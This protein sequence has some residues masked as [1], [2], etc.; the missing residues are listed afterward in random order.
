MPQ[1][2]AMQQPLKQQPL[3]PQQPMQPAQEQLPQTDEQQNKLQLMQEADRRGLLQGEM[4][5]IFDEAVRRG[6]IQAPHQ[7]Q[8]KGFRDTIRE[9]FSGAD[10]STPELEA[11]PNI[12]DAPE[13]NSLSMPAFKSSLGFLLTG[14]AE[15]QK[16][17][18]ESNFPE[19][20]FR[21][22]EKGNT[23]VALG[24][25]EYALQK[26]GLELQDIARLFT[27]YAAF[28][29]A[30]KVV[31]TTGKA[32]HGLARAFQVAKKTAATATG[33]E[34]A[35]A[36]TG[37]G[38][39]PVNIA[40]DTA[41]SGALEAVPVGVRALRG[42]A[43]K[44]A[45][46]A[47]SRAAR[48]E[49]ERVGSPVSPE[50][51]AARQTEIAEDIA[52]AARRPQQ[53][54]GLPADVQAE[55]KV[56]EAAEALDVGDVPLSVVTGD[57]Q[58]REIYE[59]L[60]SRVGSVLNKKKIESVA[61]VQDAAE[62]TI[63]QLGG[64]T[65]KAELTGAIKNRVTSEIKKLDVE[66][67]NAYN[68]V[69]NLL[70]DNTQV[71]MSGIKQA[72]QEKASKLSNVSLKDG[73]SK[74]DTLSR[75]FLDMSDSETFAFIDQERRRIGRAINKGQGIYKDEDTGA[76]KQLYGMLTDAQEQAAVRTSPE[77]AGIW[78][79]AK[80]LV[81]TRKTLEDNSVALLGKKLSD[82]VMSKMGRATRGLSK[83]DMKE[84]NEIMNA[85]PA[86]MRQEVALSSLADAFNQSGGALNFNNFNKWFEGMNRN[87]TAKDAFMKHLPD[88][89]QQRLDHLYTLSKKFE[90]AGKERITTGRLNELFSIDNTSD[91]L[92]GVAEGAVAGAA[93]AATGSPIAGGII[94][95][96]SRGKKETRVQAADRLLSSPE[97]E[98]LVRSYADVS[99]RGKA[100]QEVAAN[101]LERSTKYQRWVDILP[102]DEALNLLRSGTIA[103]FRD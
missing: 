16:G 5:D 84:F 89:A 90:L 4:K 27:Q 94:S 88:G 103:Y 45:E 43:G 62:K 34:A 10:R 23:I 86:D 80:D 28:L 44:Q 93:T 99:T 58:F 74:L 19:A 78:S 65:D 48:L 102:D 18:I 37:A 20:Q 79:T 52:E 96:L 11:L 36:A 35:A 56:Y 77:A 69:N 100:A 81:S 87:K 8:P 3:Q 24:G 21:Q 55:Q 66:V 57:Q 32:V 67:D 63:T 83:G 30:G 39:N 42:R 38:F 15:R 61:R 85:M 14:D 54:R 64:T 46:E 13:I 91:K 60:A 97:F 92:Y 51:Q 12:M 68:L 26:P 47:A 82:N 59:G 49:A 17:I 71:N 95:A 29:P 76:L 22:D 9:S 6:L 40:L 75:R 72:M 98:N 73:R 53:A 1:H 2:T 50:T 7:E 33:L 101:A 25:E 41:T 31:Q 70:P